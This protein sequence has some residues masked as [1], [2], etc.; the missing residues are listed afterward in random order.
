MTFRF[1][2][3]FALSLLLV[4]C[5]RQEKSTHAP[6][7]KPA[8]PRVTQSDRP[9][10]DPPH[11]TREPSRSSSKNAAD[12]ASPEE[13]NRTLAAEVWDALEIDPKLAREAFSQMTGGS[14]EKNRLLEHFAM[15][16]AEQNAD[17]A[18]EIALVL[19][20]KEPERAAHLLS[21]SGVAGRALDV[22]VVQVAQRWAA[23]SPADA[24]AWVVLFDAGEARTAGLKEVLSIWMDADPRAAFAWIPGLAEAPLREE[25]ELGAAHAICELPESDQKKLLKSASAG[26]RVWVEKLK[27]KAGT[28]SP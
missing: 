2:L 15:R 27:A 16:L 4:S 21:D 26:I 18:L 24:A 14:E 12:I 8:L 19:S 5:D 6:E 22:A 9:A 25:A 1:P 7:D 28:G 10:A 3:S 23:Q 20:E 17:D 13:R 11:R